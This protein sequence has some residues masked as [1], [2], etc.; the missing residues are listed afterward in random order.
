MPFVEQLLE[1]VARRGSEPLLVVLDDIHHVFDADWFPEFFVSLL[2][3]LSPRIHLLLLS[4][5]K[6]PQPLWR[7]R[8]KQVLGVIDEKLLAFNLEETGEFLRQ[9]EISPALAE[10]AH[11]ETFGRLST[12]KRFIETR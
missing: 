8:S 5:S 9:H 1:K 11:A 12:L 6:P 3:S 2:H 7:L 4:R 10:R